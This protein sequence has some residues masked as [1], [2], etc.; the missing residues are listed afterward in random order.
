M[1]GLYHFIPLKKFNFVERDQTTRIHH[2]LLLGASGGQRFATSKV[3]GV[4]C[5]WK[6]DAIL[7]TLR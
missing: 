3:E 2:Q 6:E 5:V 1:M 4:A 7:I